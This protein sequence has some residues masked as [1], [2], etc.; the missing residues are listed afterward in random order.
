MFG[1]ESQKDEILLNRL[2]IAIVDTKYMGENELFNSLTKKMKEEQT[3]FNI[4]LFN[5]LDELYKIISQNLYDSSKGLLNMQWIDLIYNIR[6]SVAIIYYYI[7]EGSTKE[8]EE[9]NISKNYEKIKSYDQNL[10]IYLFIIVPLQELDKYQHLKD[11]DKSAN[12]LRKKIK[13]EN[14]YIFSSK[15]ISKTIEIKKL[16]ENL[17]IYSRNYYRQIKNVLKRKR[18]ETQLKEEY[19]KYTIM[20]AILSTLKSKRKNPGYSKYLKE[21]YDILVGRSFNFK[22]YYYGNQENEVHNFYEVKAI[23]DWLLFKI[24]KIGNKKEEEINPSNKKKQK[25]YDK[26]KN[27]DIQ[28]KID[29]FIAHIRTFS[30]Q[31]YGK[32]ENDSFYFYNYFWKYKRLINLAEFCDKYFNELKD[33]KKYLLAISQVKFNILYTFIK[34]TKFYQKYY[35]NLDLKKVIIDSKEIPLSSISEVYNPFYGQAPI[36]VYTDENSKEENTIGFKDDI[37]LKLTIIN[38]NL[39]LDRLDETFK[40]RLIKDILSFYYKESIL[41]KGF[42]ISNFDISNEIQ[43]IGVK[44]YLNI[45]RFY[46]NYPNLNEEKNLLQYIDEKNIIFDLYQIFD[47]SLYIKNFPKLYIRF[48][49]KNI[50]YYIYQMKLHN[51]N[52]KEKFDNI[53]KTILFKSL[54]ILAS[55]K[56]LSDQEQDIFN[57]LLNDAEFIPTKYEKTKKVTNVSLEI[58]DF[59]VEGE[60]DVKD[61]E[62]SIKKEQEEKKEL[63]EKNEINNYIKENDFIISLYNSNKVYLDKEEKEKGIFFEYNIKDIEKAQN[64]KILDLVEYEF[65]ISTKLS[66]LRLKF[67]NIKIFF[68]Y[69]NQGTKKNSETEIIMKE[70]SDEYLS[71]I[72]LTSE[73]PIFLEHKIFLKYREGKIKVNK[74]LATLSDKK[75]I[76]YS[77]DFPVDIKKVI[78]IKDVSTNVLKFD[79]IKKFKVGKN[80]YNPFELKI[81]KEKNDEVEIKDL[82]IQFETLPT[83]Q[84]KELSSVINLNHKQNNNLN[85]KQEIEQNNLAKTILVLNK[86]K[87]ETNKIKEDLWSGFD[88][89]ETAVEKRISVDSELNKNKSQTSL[90]FVQNEKSKNEKTII[91]KKSLKEAIKGKK[92]NKSVQK[93]NYMH[94]EFYIYNNSENKLE[95]YSE[96]ME[97]S[98]NDFESLLNNGKNDYTT[99]IRFL[100]EGSYKIIFSVIYF[101]RHKKIEEYI[102]YREESLL[103]F[104]VV[105]PFLL[106]K[107]IISNNFFNLSENKDVKLISPDEIK[108]YYLTNCKIGIN[109]VLNNKIDKNIKIKDIQFINSNPE[110]NSIKY[111]NSYIYDLIH[112]YD[113]D[114]EEKNEILIIKK[115]SSYSFPFEMEFSQPFKGSIGKINIIWSTDS[116]DN[117]ENGKLNLL[118][119]EEYSFPEIEVRPLEFEYKYEARKNDNNEIE[120]ELRVKNISS[121]TK[122]IKVDIKNNDEIYDKQFIFIGINKQMHLITLNEEIKFNYTLVPIGKGEFDFP[123]FQLVEYDLITSEKKSINHYFSENIAIV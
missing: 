19:V 96:K 84:A 52:E 103:E 10:P 111:I 93:Q 38:N 97:I 28:T 42:E 37:F 30:S 29:I 73:T 55:I 61:K 25:V 69:T 90:E 54:S 16:Y 113:L 74:I 26:I 13:K 87:R 46:T 27:L 120:L 53:K 82:K 109:F 11:D 112:S 81:F 45:L 77:I 20:I 2:N 35:M 24:I 94:P 39:T 31:N 23:A 83:F 78:C 7:E 121:Q 122:Q 107:D 100:S 34:M 8:E 105:N 56:L 86:E 85:E 33:E 79:Y 9:I 64:R 60:T 110:N 108:R 92:E 118:N 70:F 1:N 80:Q 59:F 15:E 36:Y 102:E 57:E 116:L 6:P 68:I 63:K 89:K 115:N 99:L 51:E 21:A 101:I 50:K 104:K 114:S 5:S 62:I 17:I 72:E 66:K 75:N 44:L 76:I 4:S 98:Y 95:R 3:K 32:K 65:K 48:L 88:K 47:K 43:M 67:D 14:Y 106:S 12:S 18:S 71:N 58:N 123:C 41:E 119:K 40:K 49:S 117:F 91:G 22:T